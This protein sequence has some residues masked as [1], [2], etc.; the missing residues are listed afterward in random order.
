MHQ[1]L[2]LGVIAA[3]PRGIYLARTAHQPETAVRVAA[4][5]DPN[6]EAL[7][8]L[9]DALQTSVERYTSAAAMLDA[10]ELDAV[11]VASPDFLHEE[12]AVAA[13]ERGVGVYLEKPM[14]T[15][16]AA[17]DRV[18]AAAARNRAKLYV[19]HNMRHMPLVLKMRELIQRGAIGRVTACWA[20]HFVSRGGDAYFKDWHSERRNVTGLLVHKASHDIDV[21]HWLCGGY[22]KRVH[23]VGGLTVYGEEGT[24]RNKDQPVDDTVRMEHWPPANQ[25]GLSPTIDVEDLNMMQMELDNG[26]FASYSE[27]HYTPDNW[28]NFMVIGTAGRMENFGDKPG[29]TVIRVWNQRS[30]DYVQADEEYRV[31]AV[32][33]AHGG[34]DPNIVAEFIRYIRDGGDTLTSPIAARQAVAAGHLASESMRDGGAPKEVPPVDPEVAAYFG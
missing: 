7:Q 12:H 26:A 17:C 6:P 13:L 5:A 16:V 22:A 25:T 21:I 19:G 27:C 11:I 28:R 24:R 30:N 23:A 29:G 15:T 34:A 31:H 2:R 32:Q 3:G 20:R 1:E 14:A 9:D 10:G 8:A 4:A 33:A 18:L